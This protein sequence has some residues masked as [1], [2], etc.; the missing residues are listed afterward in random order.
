MIEKEKWNNGYFKKIHPLIRMV[1]SSGGVQGWV[2]MC[3]KLA[4]NHLILIGTQ[5]CAG[6]ELPN[7]RLNFHK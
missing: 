4:Q 1:P 6:V 5:C 3:L 7:S 2:R